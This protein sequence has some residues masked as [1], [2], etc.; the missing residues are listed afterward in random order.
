MRPTAIENFVADM[1]IRKRVEGQ[2]K[3]GQAYPPP[4]PGVYIATI[5]PYPEPPVEVKPE[6][7]P[8]VIPI[9]PETPFSK[10]EAIAEYARKRPERYGIGF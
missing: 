10:I 5:R 9:V 3:L 7:A 2:V 4:P 8:P 6:V 1:R